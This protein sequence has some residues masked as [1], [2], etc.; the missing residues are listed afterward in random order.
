[1]GN[2]SGFLSAIHHQSES[3]AKNAGS[4]SRS[5]ISDKLEE[6]SK[7]LVHDPEL[8]A[9]FVRFFLR[10]SWIKEFVLRNSNLLAFEVTIT[11]VMESFILTSN[12][13]FDTK[14]SSF[15]TENSDEFL[16][17]TATSL[18]TTSPLASYVTDPLHIAPMLMACA[19]PI[20]VASSDSCCWHKDDMCPEDGRTKSW[21]TQNSLDREEVGSHRSDLSSV[22][23]RSRLSRQ[24]T[25]AL[26]CTIGH[27]NVPL[28]KS[29]CKRD[30]F[31]HQERIA[32]LMKTYLYNI[33]HANACHISS[34]PISGFVDF[35]HSSLSQ[36]PVAVAIASVGQNFFQQR[37]FSCKNKASNDCNLPIV[38]VNKACEQFMHGKR[39]DLMSLSLHN[40]LCEQST[41]ETSKIARYRRALELMQ[42]LEMVVKRTPTEHGESCPVLVIV[43]PV[44][45]TELGVYTH[46]IVMNYELPNTSSTASNILADLPIIEVLTNLLPSVL[47]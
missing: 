25:V 30:M 23:K 4:G 6:S 3:D 1:M 16:D 24:A 29:F 31:P 28:R 8:R 37:D 7:Y 43:K 17:R 13:K 5:V 44:F 35:L 26:E 42:P 12:A 14:Q 45:N 10:G 32:V 19:Y 34:H 33:F 15:K 39:S 27:G 38:Y 2:G 46:I 47:L 18:L 9:E 40:L 22:D 11:S 36:L 41:D 20:F 21:V